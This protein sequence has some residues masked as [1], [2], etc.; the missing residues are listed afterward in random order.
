MEPKD[1]PIGSRV[2]IDAR[3]CFDGYLATVR[4]YEGKFV[5]GELSVFDRPVEL[6]LLPTDLIAVT[7]DDTPPAS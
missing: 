5:V 2:R 1:F 4:G 3:S 7:D 6:K